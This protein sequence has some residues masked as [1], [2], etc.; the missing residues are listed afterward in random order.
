MRIRTITLAVLGA[1]ALAVPAAAIGAHGNGHGKG[2]DKG[3]SKSS[4]Y[5]FKGTYA[6]DGAVDVLHGNSRVRKGGFVGQAVQFD[7]LSA[8][9]RVADTNAD[10]TSDIADVAVGD[11]VLVQARLPKGDPGA[12]PYVA[13][14]LV[15]QANPEED[16]GEVEVEETEETEGS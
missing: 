12:G 7:F 5:V 1:A 13:R 4:Q 2:H 16:D 14:R 8:D 9:V 10:G 3:K 6:G 11:R 15:D